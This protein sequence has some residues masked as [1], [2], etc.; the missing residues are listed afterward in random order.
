MG[1]DGFACD[2]TGSV[3]CEALVIATGQNL[4]RLLQQRGWGRRPFPTEAMAM[5]APPNEEP[6]PSSRHYQPNYP[7]VAVASLVAC[8]AS[9]G[10][11]ESQIRWFSI[12]VPI[13]LF[14]PRF[15]LNTLHSSFLPIFVSFPFSENLRT[16]KLIC[17]STSSAGSFSTGWSVFC[18]SSL[19]LVAGPPLF[20]VRC[21][22]LMQSGRPG[23]SWPNGSS[24]GHLN[25]LL[26]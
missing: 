23:C 2:G 17:F 22:K 5:I 14:S 4:K 16:V 21:T 25:G 15:Y 24:R 13:L 19:P 10:F 9:R 12:I 18:D 6:K 8:W 20:P 1:C 26:A 7:G 11:F 3:N